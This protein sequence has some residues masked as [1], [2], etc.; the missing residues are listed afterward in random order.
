[1]LYLYRPKVSEGARLLEDA[2]NDAGT[3]A[4]FTQGGLLR[5]RFRAGRDKLICWGSYYEAQPGL[6]NV[7]QVPKAIEAQ[8][9]KWANVRTVEISPTRPVTGPAVRPD[10][11]LDTNTTRFDEAGSQ[12]L[13]ARLQAHLA[14]PLAP[15][16]EWLPRRNNHVGGSDL[17]NRT[18]NADFYSKKEDIREEYRL[19]IFRGKSIRAG[20]KVPRENDENGNPIT[21]HAWVRSFDGGWRIQY[22]GFKS[23]KQQR[24]LAAS[25]VGALGLDFG[26]VDLGLLASGEYIVLEVNRAPGIEGGSVEAYVGAIQ[27]W[28]NGGE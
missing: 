22:D 26:A 20:V 25:A 12:A 27:N 1:M 10:F 11:I 5:D 19:H 13:L 24:S 9:L 21:P 16:A 18:V 17:L 4:R 23:N 6:N 8:T 7:I 2:L 14:A 28:L 3:P 15:A